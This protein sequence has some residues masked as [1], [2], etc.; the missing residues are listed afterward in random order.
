MKRARAIYHYVRIKNF[1]VQVQDCA[2]EW[3]EVGDLETIFIIRKSGNSRPLTLR[4]DKEAGKM[5]PCEG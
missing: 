1:K 5:G 2:C 3:V 4:K